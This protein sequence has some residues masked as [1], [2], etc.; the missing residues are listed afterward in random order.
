MFNNEF[1]LAST[2]LNDARESGQM[3]TPDQIMTVCNIN[4]VSYDAVVQILDEAQ[5]STNIS[6]TADF[7]IK[8]IAALNVAK[9]KDDDDDFLKKTTQAYL[10]FINNAQE[11][12][13]RYGD[14]ANE[15]L[16]GFQEQ[17]NSVKNL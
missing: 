1:I 10:M 6:N 8:F 3:L 14:Q 12:I 2:I 5:S 15:M 17:I 13:D 16:V 7:G 9:S 11:L 4:K